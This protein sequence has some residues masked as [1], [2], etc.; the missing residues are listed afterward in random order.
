MVLSQENENREAETAGRRECGTSVVVEKNAYVGGW[1]AI[2]GN[3]HCQADLFFNYQSLPGTFS[4]DTRIRDA[5]SFNNIF[6]HYKNKQFFH[7][8]LMYY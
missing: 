5:E 3:G 7:F 6:I 8:W 1:E 2:K 4:L